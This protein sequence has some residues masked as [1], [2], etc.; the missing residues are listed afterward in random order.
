[1]SGPFIHRPIATTLLI[2]AVVLLGLL[3]YRELPVAALPTVDFPTFEVVTPYPGASPDVVETSITAPLERYFG[4]ISGLQTMSST[5]AY[6]ISEITLQFNLSRRIDSAA[7]DVQEAINAAS[8]WI[9]VGLLPSPP[10]YREVNPADTPV[11]IL[12]LTSDTLPLHEINDYAQTVVVQKLSQIPGVGAV[13]VEGG[14]TRAV[15]L[16]V[17]PTKIAGLGL[18]L[19]D[20]RRGIA[21]T[22]SD[23]PK[24]TLDGPRQAFQVDANDQLFE[25]RSYRDAVIAYRNGAP[26]LLRDIGSAVDAVEDADQAAWYQGKIAVVLDIQRQ[27]G[28]NTIEVVDAVRA[29]LPKLQDVAAALAQDRRRDRPHR[30]DPR[31]DRRC[32]VHPG[33]DRRA[34]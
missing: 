21:A 7:E 18:S 5:S 15:R 9:P 3:G 29:L 4:A 13:T 16:Q 10:V 25:A 17:N 1:M 24:G 20:V 6:G 12:A 23:Q 22:T 34:W 11:L 8:G 33:A 30:N 26:V 31:G 27:P 28:A 14:L 32:A 19:E 2:V